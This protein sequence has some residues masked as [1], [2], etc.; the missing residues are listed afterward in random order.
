MPLQA[1]TRALNETKSNQSINKP[2]LCPPDSDGLHDPQPVFTT[3]FAGAYAPTL[4]DGSLILV[5][6]AIGMIEVVL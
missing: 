4:M 2:V 6:L 1:R 3:S 5:L